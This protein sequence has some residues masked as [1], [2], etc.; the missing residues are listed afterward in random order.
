MLILSTSHWQPWWLH[1]SRNMVSW[2]CTS[3]WQPWWW[4]SLR[5]IVQVMVY[6]TLATLMATF[7]QEHG[8]CDGVLN[9]GNHNTLIATF[10]KEHGV[11]DGVLNTGNPDGNPWEPAVTHFPLVYDVQW[12]T[13]GNVLYTQGCNVTTS[14]QWLCIFY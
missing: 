7:I 12:Y 5:N 2:W 13:C 9:N 6:S 10:I 1:S 8:V 11:C 14:H 4:H 3:H